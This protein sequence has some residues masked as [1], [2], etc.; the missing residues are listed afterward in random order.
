M[1]QFVQLVVDVAQG[2][3]V[4]LAD[5][6]ALFLFTLFGDVADEEYP[7]CRYGRSRAAQRNDE[8]G[9]PVPFAVAAKAA[10]FGGDFHAAFAELLAYVAPDESGEEA[11]RS[12]GVDE[13]CGYSVD[14]AVLVVIHGI[15]GVSAA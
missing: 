1:F 6:A 4:L 9:N 5:A 11:F 3:I 7:P 8:G 14:I 12:S 2:V 13:G 15:M 10:V